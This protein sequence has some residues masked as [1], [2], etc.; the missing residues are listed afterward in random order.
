MS[1]TASSTTAATFTNP[2]A[3]FVQQSS[4]MVALME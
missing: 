4:Q 1:L 3:A 2:L